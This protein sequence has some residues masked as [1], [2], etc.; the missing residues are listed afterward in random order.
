MS[1]SITAESH[2]AGSVHLASES[3]R[4][5]SFVGLLFTQ[6]LTATNDN[7]FRWLVIG[8][9][10]DYFPTNTTL[11]LSIGTA[12]FV[13]PYLFLA[14]PA[15]YLADRFSKRNVIIAC[16]V[17]ELAIMAIGVAAIVLGQ[18]YLLFVVVALMGAQSALFSP[19]KLGAIPELLKPG[20]ISEANG[21]FGLTT[22]VSTVIGMAVGNYLSDVTGEFGRENPAPGA[23]VLLGVA[24]VGLAFSF[25]IR[26]LPIAN[27]KRTFP[28]NA[29]QQTWRDIKTLASHAAL[30]RVALGI[31]FFWS[32]GAIAQLNIDQL[33]AEGGATTDA[34]KNPLLISLIVGVGVGSV[35]AG[36]WSRGHVE[37]GIL[38]LGAAGIA[39]AGM[40]LFTT[41]AHIFEPNGEF[42]DGMIWTC[43]LL[44]FLGV[45]AGLFSV[46]LEAF[47]QHR[48][49]ADRRGS[50]LA[51]M[52]F[53]VFFGVLVTSMLYAVLRVPIRGEPWLNA[54]EIFLVFGVLTVPVFIY[55]VVSIPQATVRF[56]VWLLSIF[57]YRIRIYGRENLPNE[58][59]ALLVPNHVSWL[60]G[61]L[62]GVTSSR[63]IRMVVWGASIRSRTLQWLIDRFGVIPLSSRPKELAAAIKTA[64]E[65]LNNGELVCVFAEGG[66][67]RTGQVQAFRPGIMKILQGTDAPVVPVYLDELW[68]SIFSF[69]GGR[70]FWKRPRRWRYPVSI[71]FG[72]PVARREDLHHIRQA[73]QHLG[74]QAVQQRSDN[75]TPVPVGFI[76]QCKRRRFT[77]KMRDTMGGELKGGELLLRSLILR[78]LL[79]RHVLK[80]DEQYVGLLLPPTAGGVIA[81]VALTLDRRIAVNLNYST[82][83]EVINGCIEDAGVKHVLTSRQFMSK[84][85]FD[86]KSELVYLEDFK[87][88]VTR[89]DKV[90]GAIGAY[91]TPAGILARQLGLNRIHPDDVLTVIFTSGSTGR[92]KGVMLTHKNVASNVEAIDQVIH[93]THDDVLLCVLPFFHSLGYTVTLWGAM[94]LDI[95]GAYHYTPLDAKRI[96][97]LCRESGA[98]VLLATPTFLRSYLRRCE[99][100]EMESLDVVVAGAEK[101]PKDLCDAFEEKFGVR[102]VEGYGATELSPLVSVNIPPSRSFDNFQTTLKEGT[103]GRPVPAVS[104]KVVHL[105]T[106]EELSAGQ[107]G[108]LLVTG[109]NVM[110]G[111]LH[112][113]KETAEVLRDGWY[114]TGDVALID[115]DGFI[116]ITGRESRFSKIGGEMVPHIAIE[117]AI[118]RIV[119]ASEEEGPKCAVTAVPDARKGER[120]IVIHTPLQKN[121][122]E[123]CKALSEQGFSNLFIPDEEAFLEVQELPVL[124][125]G[126]LDLKGIKQVAMAHYAPSE[127]AA[128][129][130]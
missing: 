5:V 75:Y 11:V 51:A 23:A 12:F 99:K 122:G 21:L 69:E 106:G 70:F 45:S 29:P 13:A 124:G 101:L 34:A 127:A 92:P 24:A 47:M 31:L 61:V 90:A 83:S 115:E 17:A 98:T 54:R 35:L 86:I 6:L 25:L 125:S 107:E 80:D 100:E 91:V 119:G 37:L 32:V 46:P 120:L 44:L 73:V 78:R 76:R 128:K 94:T 65:A 118:N 41:P 130:K 18:I 110:K 2:A 93:L 63:P 14:A 30:F 71:H 66:I 64:R 74:T 28:W 116:K 102:P 55:I 15:G 59:G 117:E 50:I 58:G 19:S 105:E 96:G 20:K 84:M 1:Q 57:L 79:R 72:P 129:S 95:Q 62:L 43:V 82:S 68:G 121:P 85:N 22:V 112:R 4:S 52:N 123:I 56:G 126:K 111:Y 39:V 40:L 26:P 77:P 38:P 113:E 89:A 42:T 16:K 53:L 36:I 114:V 48:S 3:L 109:P 8:I 60:D 88:K 10:K 49:P 97:K 9:G 67:S 27:L 103:V 104:A 33:A 81:N 87:T 7:I 108:M